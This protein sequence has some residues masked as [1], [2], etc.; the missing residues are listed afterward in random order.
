MTVSIAH[1]SV[2][3]LRFGTAAV[4]YFSGIC[5]GHALLSLAILLHLQKQIYAALPSVS[6]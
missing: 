2:L 4:E 1:S 6:S 5:K 3:N